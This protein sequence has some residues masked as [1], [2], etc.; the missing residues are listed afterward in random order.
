REVP[1]T[2]TVGGVPVMRRGSPASDLASQP[3]R[4]PLTELPE[5][6]SDHRAAVWLLTIA[7]IVPFVIR[8]RRIERSHRGH[9]RHD[10][11]VEDALPLELRD[12]LARLTLLLRRMVEDH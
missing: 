2:V 10:R 4:E 5:L 6:R 11:I 3:M 9:L 1:R 12:H 7:A 8:L